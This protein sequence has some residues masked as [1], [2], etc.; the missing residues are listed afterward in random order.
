MLPPKPRLER[1][2]EGV[3]AARDDNQAPLLGEFDLAE[4]DAAAPGAGGKRRLPASPFPGGST[5]S[6][7]A[8]S[9]RADNGVWARGFGGPGITRG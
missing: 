7:E 1:A 5:R 6:R 9:L 3:H 2:G 4:A 8:P